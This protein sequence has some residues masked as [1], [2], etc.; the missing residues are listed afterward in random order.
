VHAS[1]IRG[2]DGLALGGP[3]AGGGPGIAQSG[4]FLFLAGSSV[5]GG[6]GA[7]ALD[8]VACD[9]G[10]DGGHGL[11]LEGF[12]P[13]QQ[14]HDSSVLGGAG[15]AAVCGLAGADGV[16]RLE[17]VPSKITDYPGETVGVEV[18]PRPAHDAPQTFTVTGAPGDVVFLI[19]SFLHDTTDV[20][21]GVGWL[22]LMEP[23]PVL[24][25]AQLPPSGTLAIQRPL[26]PGIFPAFASLTCYLQPLAL[27]AGG[28]LVYGAPASFA[29]LSPPR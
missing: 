8:G 29:V 21:G 16:P 18:V 4:G 26:P 19:C 2:G 14:T 15:G 10:G 22:L 5:Q 27:G 23:A 20:P 24:G 9:D 11:V 12:F 7:D 17:L 25:T 1:R 6:D 13:A 3:P 28:A